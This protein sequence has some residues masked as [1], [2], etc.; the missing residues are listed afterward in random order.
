MERVVNDCWMLGEFGE[1]NGRDFEAYGGVCW[2]REVA[3]FLVEGRRRE[4]L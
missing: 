1:G 4:L 3:E 2:E